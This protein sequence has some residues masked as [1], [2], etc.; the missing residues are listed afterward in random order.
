IKYLAR[1][2]KNNFI[3]INLDAHTDTSE[4]IGKDVPGKGWMD[5]TL[6]EAMKKGWWVLLDEI[7]LAEPE[8][9]ERINSL[10]DDDGYLVISEH[11]GERVK[12]HPNFRLFAAMNPAA[13]TG[14]NRL[15]VAMRNKFTER[16]VGAQID[17]EELKEIIDFYLTDQNISKLEAL[18][19]KNVRDIAEE[20]T[21]IFVKI[22][23][24]IKDGRL[25]RGKISGAELG[26]YNFSLRDI[27]DWCDFV[28]KMHASMDTAKALIEGALY[29]FRDRLEGTDD[30]KIFKEDVLTII[31]QEKLTDTPVN[32][33]KLDILEEEGKGEIELLLQNMSIFAGLSPEEIEKAQLLE[34]FSELTATLPSELADGVKE[35]RN[36][37]TQ[38]GE[39][40]NAVRGFALLPEEIARILIDMAIGSGNPDTRKAA[41]E[42]VGHLG[43]SEFSGNLLDMLNDTEFEVRVTA[44]LVLE[45]LN[46]EFVPQAIPRIAAR[47]KNLSKLGTFKRLEVGKTG[48]MWSALAIGS[49]SLL[50]GA[51]IG[52]FA[53]PGL[54]G[55]TSGIGL[56]LLT[57]LG[58]QIVASLVFFGLLPAISRFLVYY[59]Q[60]KIAN[61][62]YK[63]IPLDLEDYTKLL[64]ED[65]FD[66]FLKFPF[67]KETHK[68]ILMRHVLAKRSLHI[69]F[70]IVIGFLALL[71]VYPVHSMMR[72]FPVIFGNFWFFMGVAT[73]AGFFFGFFIPI[74]ALALAETLF[75][76]FYTVKALTYGRSIP[77]G[78]KT[79]EM[80]LPYDDKTIKMFDQFKKK[81]KMRARMASQI[82]E[83]ESPLLEIES[84]M[85]RN[86]IKIEGDKLII[87]DVSLPIQADGMK[88]HVPQLETSELIPTVS[89]VR[90][91]KKVA[92]SIL[93]NDPTLLVGETA[94]GKTSLI[95]YLASLTN[96][97]FRRFNLNGM[98]DKTEFIGGIKPDPDTDFAWKEGILTKAMRDGHWLVLDEI[99]LAESQVL[100]R[101][102]SLLDSGVL[103]ITEHDNETWLMPEVYEKRLSELAGEIAD[104]KKISLSE[105]RKLAK[106]EMDD[107]NFHRIN[108]NFRLFA[109]MN[110]A[111]YS[112]RKVLSPAF[113]N[114]FRVKWMDELFSKEKKAVLYNKFVDKSG[115]KIFTPKFLGYIE[116]FHCQIDQLAKT[117]V[118]GSGEIDPYRYTMR[119]LIRLG[120]RV[121][122]KVNEAIDNGEEPSTEFIERLTLC[123]FIEVY[124]DRIRTQ[125]DNN[126]DYESIVELVADCGLYDDLS[127]EDE[128]CEIDE[129]HPDYVSF[130]DIKINKW[131][132]GG[133]YVPEDWA[134][135]TPTKTMKKYLKK[136]IK[137]AAYDENV[138]MVGP[139][140]AAKTS[141]VR[142]A[143][144][145]T[146]HN[147]M[148]INLD[149]QTDTTQFIGQHLPKEGTEGDFEWHYG[150]LI[151][152]MKEGYWVLL[153]EINLADPE[154][155]DRLASLF[156]DDR[157]L[158]ITENE[159]EKW[160]S[161]KEYQ[162]RVKKYAEEERANGRKESEEKLEKEA[163]EKLTEKKI[164]EIHKDFKIF[165]AM[166][167]ERYSGRNRLSLAMRNR[168]TELW[169]PSELPEDE[170]IEIVTSKLDDAIKNK[171]DMAEKTVATHKLIM[172]AV[173]IFTGGG[174]DTYQFSNR[175]LFNVWTK[176]VNKYY[177]K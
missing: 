165:A 119:D 127:L 137:A 111:E 16:W 88:E 17:P 112:G 60:Y 107:E 15:S 27:K 8:I 132:K 18:P 155:I 52:H 71:A 10:L 135:L 142:H 95:R 174:F 28:R 40:P 103:K 37:I 61:K 160:I 175:E 123:E 139:T 20:M 90:N 55:I 87:G 84:A 171:G 164:F 83:E 161:H 163:E 13:Y 76:S 54:L 80:T 166:N 82:T 117:R 79:Y 92:M 130:G 14:R 1:L 176:Y 98:T 26:S 141:F 118:I 148:R 74:V 177:E 33:D 89:T 96:N 93:L 4:I 21:R 31:E 57:V 129:S 45:K 138:L 35:I 65:Q 172:E 153:D 56:N 109:T 143:A 39:F 159:D 145:I 94:V 36:R 136:I 121:L 6:V 3:R 116:W 77:T 173:E 124:T 19:R 29:V 59:P 169:V 43:L 147:F 146:G 99:N 105:A 63:T 48:F 53:L 47:P 5:G 122:R 162:R 44:A 34:K 108:E 128:D 144:Y 110:P 140:G 72:F 120:E 156:D 170:M 42:V 23:E 167:P 51:Y 78:R 149:A 115:K 157:S 58:V 106:E 12:P 133:P 50:F 85:K 168:F 75:E 134:R 152:A 2:T 64:T 70:G 150:D 101:L 7:N 102:N 30:K 67:K 49:L 86:A 66:S 97:G 73:L 9:L 131:K 24:M 69:M 114:R 104:K 41:A 125:D 32:L 154:I 81:Q 91:L 25:G 113:V 38:D 68:R 151:R 11:N 46:F 62:R 126:A 100:E 22:N 158:V